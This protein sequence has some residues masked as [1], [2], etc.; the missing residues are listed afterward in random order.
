MSK[1][2][3][4]PS[5][6]KNLV[7]YGKKKQFKRK[8]FGLCL[9]KPLRK[10]STIVM[11]LMLMS[12]VRTRLKSLQTAATPYACNKISK[13]QCMLTWIH[14]WLPVYPIIPKYW[15]P[16]AQ[17]YLNVLRLLPLLHLHVHDV[18][19]TY[20][21]WEVGREIRSIPK[22]KSILWPKVFLPQGML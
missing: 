16:R 17:E 5:M 12:L 21:A 14:W 7:V 18:C 2:L 4:F 9:R 11:L 22:H 20:K 15:N 6:L 13:Y 1:K 10:I 19:W 8:F 3:H